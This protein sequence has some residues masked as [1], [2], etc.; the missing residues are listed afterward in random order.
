MDGVTPNSHVSGIVGNVEIRLDEDH[1]DPRTELDSHANMVVLGAHCFIFEWSGKTCAVQPFTSDL[2]TLKSVP[3]VDAAI[4]YDCPITHLSY[5]LL[6]RNALYMPNLKHNLIPPFLMREAGLVINDTAKIH[7][8]DPTPLDHAVSFPDKELIIPLHLNGIFSFFHTRKPNEEELESLDKIFI[9]PDSSWWN[10]YCRSFELNERSMTQYD[11]EITPLERQTRL[12]HDNQT[13]ESFVSSVSLEQYDAT[14]D[15]VAEHAFVAEDHKP[16]IGQDE[17]FL[18]ALEN[19]AEISKAMS[20]LGTIGSSSSQEDLFDGPSIYPI[21]LLENKLKTILSDMEFEGTMAHLNAVRSMSQKGVTAEQLSK[22]WMIDETLAKGAL[23]KSTQLCKRHTDSNLSRNFSTN[24]RML[25][26]KRLRSVFFT[27]TLVAINTKSLRGNLYAQIFV[28]DKGYVAVYPMRSQSEFKQ[29]LHWFCKE[30]GVP[31]SL[32][33]DGHKAQRNLSTK[34]FCHQVGTIMRVLEVGTPWANRAELYIGL[35]KE[36]VRRDLRDSHAPKVLWDYCLERRAHIHNF[37]PRPLFQNQGETPHNVTFGEQGDISN[38]CT[39][40]WYDWVYYR[41]P[42][43]FPNAREC[44]GRALGPAKNEGSEMSQW[45]LTAQATVVPRRTLR[46]LTDTELRSETEKRRRDIFTDVI[47]QRLG[48]SL[49]TPSKL[50]YNEYVAYEDGELGHP[51]LDKVDED[52]LN[53]DGKAAFEKPL[54]DVWINAEVSLPQGE[55]LQPAKVI[56]RTKSATGDI[57][58]TYDPN[59][60]M[61]TLVYD[62][63][64]PDG[65]VR[66]YSANTIA[67]NIYNQVDS[68]GYHSSTLVSI[69]DYKKLPNALSK[70]DMYVTT[71]SGQRRARKTSKGWDLLV[72]WLD[73]SESW[74]PLSIVKQSYP[75]EAAEFAVSVGI[76]KEPA[77]SWWV[78]YTLRKRDTIVSAVKARVKRV[79][80]KYGVEI[81][82]TVAEALKLDEINGN[83]HWRDAIDKEMTNLKVA[84]DILNEGTPMKPGY[85]KASG[86]I[87]FDVR[88]T[89]ERK[90]RWVKDGHKTP[91]PE[92][93]TYAGVVSRESVRIALTYAALNLLDVC[94]CDIQNAYLQSPSSEKHYIICGPEFGLENVGKRA[95]IVRALYGGKGAGADYWRHVRSAMDD[96]GFTSCKADPDVWFRP[97]TKENGTDYY[98]Y[99]LLYTDDILAIMVNPETFIRDELSRKF[100][101]K[102][103]SIGQPTQYLGNKVSKVTMENGVLAW[104]FSSSQY[105]QNAVKNV[106]TFL[107]KTS[108]KLPPNPKS[109]WTTNYRPEVDISPELGNANAAYYQSLIGILRWICELGRVDITMETSAM[110]SMMASPREGHLNQLYRMFAFLKARHNGAMVFDPTVPDINDT[111]FQREEWSATA[112]STKREEIPG[113]MP[114]PRG[115]GFLMRAFVDSDHAGDLITRRSRTGFIIFLNS[116]PIYWNSKKQGSVETSSFGSEFMAL[117]NCC[118]YIRGLQYKLRMM[119]IPVELPTYIFADNQSVLKNST[120]PHSTLKKKSSSIAF[121]FVR[122]GTARDEWRL[123]YLN[124]HLN[125][126]DMLTKSL[127]GGEKR[128]LFTSFILHY[129]N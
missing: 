50:N 12:L 18:N 74:V 10:P 24:D 68:D 65:I 121:H 97:G 62:V 70:D 91:E 36:A 80:H 59:P 94:A 47:S 90:A 105:I 86:H 32:V 20:T 21:G 35:L 45:V 85:S 99:V 88:M 123:T 28:S 95:I 81:P 22:I 31:A 58:G 101:V 79:T 100:V 78:P 69:V 4:A 13:T 67:E 46:S 42:G 27:D 1:E 39:F 109:P 112:Y 17:D 125:P 115:V 111:L 56:G 60:L 89:L 128:T 118:E 6:I 75:I 41:N 19:R 92:M 15:T 73:G 66:E 98:Q 124:T 30:V 48:D 110:A 114:T 64:F 8:P 7:C 83:T 103:K 77:F 96:M 93:S 102:E 55:K 9:T 33:M 44:L 16:A 25:R 49:E 120:L 2:G 116:A 71:Q 26:Y 14:V 5:V 40:S 51:Q 53:E 3:I 11:G 37:V 104:C 119:G 76:D 52:P 113:N 82:R 106:E 29:A 129:V 61:N 72:S 127:P 84:F 57:I 54:T 38:V 117:K 108:K 23:D 34:K 126:S 122:E 43:N 87:V 63:E 107:A